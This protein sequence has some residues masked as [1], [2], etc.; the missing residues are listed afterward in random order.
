MGLDLNHDLSIVNAAFPPSGTTLELGYV[1]RDGT[2]VQIPYLTQFGDY[3]QRV[4]IVNRGTAADY[5]FSFTNEEDGPTI[6]PGQMLREPWRGE[7]LRTSA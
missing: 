4:V 1:M 3:N 2:T 7:P 5:S 6:T